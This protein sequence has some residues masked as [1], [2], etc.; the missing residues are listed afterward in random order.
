ERAIALREATRLSAAETACR[1]AVALYARAEGRDHPDVA[2]ALVELGRILEVRDRL[3]DARRCQAR[4]LAILGRPPRGGAD[5]PDVARLRVRARVFLAGLDRALGAHAAA[6]RGF[7]VALREVTRAFGP[8]D[9]D[10]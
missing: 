6:E 10:V 9:P 8:R 5:D 1:R 4:A 7:R 2:N 3:R